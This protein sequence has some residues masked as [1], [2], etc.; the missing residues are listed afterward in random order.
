MPDAVV[1][2]SIVYYPY[3]NKICAY[4]IPSS[5]WSLIPDCPARGF[6]STVI[7]GLLTAVGGYIGGKT[8]NKPFSLTGKGS[9]RRWTEKFPPM[10][11]KHYPVSALCTGTTLVLAGGKYG[12]NHKFKTVEVLNTETGQ[13]HTAPDLPEPLA[14][15]SITLCGDLVYLLGE[16]IKTELL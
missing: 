7:D 6:A 9:G 12:M 16:S 4:H 1:W 13:W 8:T 10:P 2:N 5:T 3:N 14:E 11:T 15:S